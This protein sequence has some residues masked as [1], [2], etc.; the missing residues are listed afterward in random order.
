VANH[1][2]S[3]AFPGFFSA[4]NFIYLSRVNDDSD[5][6]WHDTHTTPFGESYFYGCS[7]DASS[8]AFSLFTASQLVSVLHQADATDRSQFN[9]PFT[10][11]VG[12]LDALLARYSPQLQHVSIAYK[13]S[14]EHELLSDEVE[15]SDESPGWLSLCNRLASVCPRLEALDLRAHHQ[16]DYADT[17]ESVVAALDA[18]QAAVL[19]AV[20]VVKSVEPARLDVRLRMN[21]QIKRMPQL[22]R[23]SAEG[24]E[25]D[26][27]EERWRV[28]RQHPLFQVGELVLEHE[29]GR[30][31]RRVV[32]E[33]MEIGGARLVTFNVEVKNEYD[34]TLDC[35]C[36][37]R[38]NRRSWMID[39]IEDGDA[40]DGRVAEEWDGK[41]WRARRIWLRS[42]RARRCQSL[43]ALRRRKGTMG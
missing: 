18:F 35:A 30:E 40:D 17:G 19:R 8:D 23:P 12:F 9:G 29:R 14:N 25:G 31:V 3:N 7:K 42:Q 20:G 4:E 28:P 41:E 16:G 38:R 5:R 37:N 33:W 21:L 36:C 26:D 27:D 13:W 22:Y 24:W 32:E 39:R 15:M 10:V 6:Y 34:S 2:F 1:V 11:R 43:A